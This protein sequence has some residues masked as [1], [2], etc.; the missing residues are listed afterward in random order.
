[1][2][3][4]LIIFLIGFVVAILVYAKTKR[5]SYGQFVMAISIIIA[6]VIGVITGHAD[7]LWRGLLVGIAWVVWAVIA[8]H[9]ESNLSGH[10]IK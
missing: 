2:D 9:R 3:F 10:T 4:S 6:G 7:E 8:Y 5:N 1:M